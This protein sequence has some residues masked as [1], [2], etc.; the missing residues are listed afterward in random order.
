M[1]RSR[2][3]SNRLPLL[4]AICSLSAISE[5]R[6]NV[7][8]G[9]FETGSFAGWQTFGDARIATSALGTGPTEGLYQAVISSGTGSVPFSDLVGASTAFV[10]V[11]GSAIL[12]PT[13]PSHVPA[14][15]GSMIRQVFRIE[16]SGDISFD[17]TFLYNG[18]D[19]FRSFGEIA[20]VAFYNPLR[21]ER[22]YHGAGNT[23]GNPL[24]DSRRGVPS[25]T[26]YELETPLS[27]RHVTLFLPYSGEWIMEAGILDLGI[28]GDAALVLDNFQ[29]TRR[30]RE[31]NSVPET[32]S[33][34]ALLFVGLVGL[35]MYRRFVS[36]VS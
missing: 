13:H 3:M 8:N 16:G 9:G 28:N 20:L 25:L 17:K 15:E 24:T 31:G 30:E 33:T 36:S 21:G 26:E 7:I 5:L 12:D 34:L 1:V 6:A 23:T 2:F 22:P 27:M 19:S 18:F 32:T 11:L 35:G 29:F 10:P 4:F 14:I